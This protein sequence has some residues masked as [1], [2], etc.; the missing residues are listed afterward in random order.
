M[1]EFVK[2]FLF[3]LS[4]E[5]EQNFCG[6]EDRT[7]LSIPASSVFMLFHSENSSSTDYGYKFKIKAYCKRTRIPPNLH[8]LPSFSL[9]A[10]IKMLGMVAFKNLLEGCNSIIPFSFDLISPLMKS[11]LITRP[12]SLVPDLTES[13]T[14]PLIF[15]SSHPVRFLCISFFF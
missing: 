10:H 13:S 8:F 7:P 9:L 5:G 6:C 3:V 12:E 1:L 11:A 15:E 2:F 14:K 4:Q